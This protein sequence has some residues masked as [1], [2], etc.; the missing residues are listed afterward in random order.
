MNPLKTTSLAMALTLAVGC[1]DPLA[2][3]RQDFIAGCSRDIPA[4]ICECAFEKIE[5][6]YSV[7][8]IAAVSRGT[9]DDRLAA[10]SQ[11]TLKALYECRN[12][13]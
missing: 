4:V 2:E 10:I 7:E 8:E 11:D 3:Q 1:S 9:R 5:D 13:R 6:K 12:V